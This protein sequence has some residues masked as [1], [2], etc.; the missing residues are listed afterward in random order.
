MDVELSDD[1]D[2]EAR[3]GLLGNAKKGLLSDNAPAAAAATADAAAAAAAAPPSDEVWEVQ[4]ETT[5]R[6]LPN[7]PTH[8]AK[9]PV[10]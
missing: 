10:R 2:V 1:V 5:Q 4:W 3:S 8:P 9:P 6:I 7:H